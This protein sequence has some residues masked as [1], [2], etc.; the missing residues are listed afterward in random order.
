MNF[1][2]LKTEELIDICGG[3]II[4]EW[5]DDVKYIYSDIKRNWDNMQDFVNGFWDGL[6]GR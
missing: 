5:Y 3:S 2:D 4:R 1:L 6:T